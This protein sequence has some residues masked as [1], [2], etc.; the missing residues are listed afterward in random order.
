VR[1]DWMRIRLSIFV[2]IAMVVVITG[3]GGGSS[4]TGTTTAASTGTTSVNTPVATTP[5]SGKP[6]SAVQLSSSAT[7]ICKRLNTELETHHVVPNSQQRILDITERR[8]ALERK[9]LAE[10]S[11]LTPP[12]TI[13]RY[14]RQIL[15]LRQ[16]II[17][18]LEKLHADALSGNSAAEKSV[19]KGST[20]IE[21]RT[22]APARRAGVTTCAYVI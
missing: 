14:W 5:A 2:V 9:A 11:S 3:C 17:D 15:A 13:A 8:L 6:L 10:L 16:S 18:D 7:A 4:S 19:F 1:L 21:E 12:A 20:G 22:V